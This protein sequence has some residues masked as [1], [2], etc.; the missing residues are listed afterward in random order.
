MPVIPVLGKLRQED[1]RF[2]ISLSNLMRPYFKIKSKRELGVECPW[3]QSPVTY[4]DGHTH[5][6]THTELFFESG[7]LRKNSSGYRFQRTEAKRS[8]TYCTQ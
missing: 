3:V 5:T 4:L 2:N 7:E 8:S 1:C 6:H